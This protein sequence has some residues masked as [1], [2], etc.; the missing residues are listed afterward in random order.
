MFLQFSK[1]TNQGDLWKNAINCWKG[2]GA[3][4]VSRVIIRVLGL[5]TFGVLCN[6]VGSFETSYMSLHVNQSNSPELN[7]VI[8]H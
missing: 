7:A 1:N 6:L 5:L 8:S 2:E 3:W 4:H